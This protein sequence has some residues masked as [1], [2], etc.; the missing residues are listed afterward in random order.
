MGSGAGVGWLGVTNSCVL[1]W[2]G[3]AGGVMKEKYSDTILWGSSIFK[4]AQLSFYSHCLQVLL[5]CPWSEQPPTEAPIAEEEEEERLFRFVDGE[6]VVEGEEEE[7]VE[8]DIEVVEHEVVRQEE[9][10]DLWTKSMDEWAERQR[11]SALKQTCQFY[12]ILVAGLCTL[13]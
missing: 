8:E 12:I 7:E 5:T 9:E 6:M 1:G 4:S 13:K 2:R 3:G 10:E 11:S